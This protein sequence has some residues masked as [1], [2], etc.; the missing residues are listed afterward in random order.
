MSKHTEC[1]YWIEKKAR[2][3]SEGVIVGTHIHCRNCG[4]CIINGQHICVNADAYGKASRF[5]AL[6]RRLHE[7]S[8]V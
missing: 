3:K 8:S 1:D 2:L 7:R 6:G 4:S 5:F